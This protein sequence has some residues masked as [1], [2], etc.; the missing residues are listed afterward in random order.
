MKRTLITAF[1][2]SALLL[3]GCSSESTTATEAASTT[4]T[5]TEAAPVAECPT[6]NPI[7]DPAVAAAV[8]SVP[9]ANGATYRGGRISTDSD[10]PGM[11]AV[12]ITLCDPNITTADA[13]RPVATSYARAL[14][15][16]PA[17]EQ[18]FAVY[19][20]TF[21]V[22]GSDVVNEVKLKDGEFQTHLWNGKPSEAAEQARWEVIAG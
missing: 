14:K 9:L 21:Q 16:S 10:E 6:D 20:E 5:M 15:A 8:A 12:A 22:S 2:A 4:T 11:F 3:A 1:G 17:A 18:V 19:V 13:L 7:P